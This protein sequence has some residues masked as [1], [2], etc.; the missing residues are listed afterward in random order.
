MNLERQVP[1]DVIGVIFFVV[2]SV[3]FIVVPP[4]NATP[5][6]IIVGFPL[7]LFLPGYSLICAL[8]PKKD[9]MDGIERI[10]LSIGLSIAVV[11]IIGLMLNYTPWGIRLSPIL[12]AISSFTLILAAVTA[13]RRARSGREEEPDW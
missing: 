4:L 12:L 6:R 9:E 8:F 10:A 1:K 13:A 3:F 7:V 2:I 11:V 5:L